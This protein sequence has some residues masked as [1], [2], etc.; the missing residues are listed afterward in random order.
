MTKIDEA[1]VRACIEALPKNDDPL[2]DYVSGANSI[3]Q[4]REALEAL[5]PKPVDPAEKLVKDW[6]SDM[7]YSVHGIVARICLPFAQWMIAR[8]PRAD[9][10]LPIPALQIVREARGWCTDMQK[11]KSY[12]C[13]DHDN[14][15][16]MLVAIAII[17]AWKG[18]KLW[19]I[20]KPPCSWPRTS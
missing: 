1:T 16:E 2:K 6:C 10:D 3:K 17:T 14:S 5:L 19:A 4:C 12:L 20:D 9:I 15:P 8:Q 18:E 7:D 11:T 13:G